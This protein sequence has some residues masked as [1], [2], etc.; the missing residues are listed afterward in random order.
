MIE[1]NQLI[2]LW[3]KS[4]NPLIE[5]KNNPSHTPTHTRTYTRA[6]KQKKIF[7]S[8]LEINGTPMNGK[9]RLWVRREG[10][11]TLR[12]L[13]NVKNFWQKRSEKQFFFDGWMNGWMDGLED[14]RWNWKLQNIQWLRIKDSF[15]LFSS[16]LQLWPLFK[17]K[18]DI[19]FD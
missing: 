18:D 9:E 13:R 8:F 3:L 5:A 15:P 19:D 16:S 14:S 12:M 17:N 6:H 7:T 10:S 1:I 11:E 2:E 4:I